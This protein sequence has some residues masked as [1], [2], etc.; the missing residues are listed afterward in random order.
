MEKVPQSPLM[1]EVAREFRERYNPQKIDI[2]SK[3]A[4]DIQ[5]RTEENKE[6]ANSFKN[7][8]FESQDYL[9]TCIIKEHKRRRASG[10]GRDEAE[11]VAENDA[12]RRYSH[13]GLM[14]MIAGY[15]R[16]VRRTIELPSRSLYYPFPIKEV[17]SQIYT[18]L[19]NTR[20]IYDESFQ[21]RTLL[22]EASIYLALGTENN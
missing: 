22:G 1:I 12:S 20:G 21:H 15:V 17:S 6:L 11:R 5:K 10:G 4:K 9:R 16:N 18:D 7:L 3:H 14:S 2:F 13:N 8:I 19:L